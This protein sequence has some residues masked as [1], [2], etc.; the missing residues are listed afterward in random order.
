M[1]TSTEQIPTFEAPV[2]QSS[3]PKLTVAQTL[4]AKAVARAQKAAA[5]AAEKAEK[6]AARLAAKNQ[7]KICID[8]GCNSSIKWRGSRNKKLV[9]NSCFF[10]KRRLRLSIEELDRVVIEL[11]KTDDFDEAREL[12]LNSKLLLSNS[13]LKKFYTTQTQLF[14]KNSNKIS[15]QSTDEDSEDSLSVHSDDDGAPHAE[16]DDDDNGASHVLKRQKTMP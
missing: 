16:H 5:K 6:A 14:H 7:E 4:A 11:L 1:Q 2:S 8:C 15:V 3:E 10:R 13:R 9:C 12:L